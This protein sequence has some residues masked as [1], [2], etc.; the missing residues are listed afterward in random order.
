MRVA[1]FTGESTMGR[2]RCLCMLA[3]CLAL[4]PMV[5]PAEL[6]KLRVTLQLPE[7][8]HIAVNLAQFKAEVEQRTEGAVAFEI[9]DNSKLYSDEEV[10][11][12]VSSGAIEMGITNYNQF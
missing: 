5:A 8:S 12:A 9:F 4:A 2:A 10:I 7:K 6:I 1:T 3:A 11:G